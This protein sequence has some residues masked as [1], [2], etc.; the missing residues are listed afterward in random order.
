MTVRLLL[1]YYGQPANSLITLTSA[2]ETQLVNAKM[3]STNL[4][5]G[6][7]YTAPAPN[8]KNIAD[9]NLAID[10]NGNATLV[11]AALRFPLNPSLRTVGYENEQPAAI[12]GPVRNFGKVVTNFTNGKWLT[13]AGTPTLTQGYTGW[14]GSGAKSGITSRTGQPEMLKVVPAANTTE[15]ITLQVPATNL[16]N[17]ATAGKLGLWVYLEAQPGYQAGGTLTGGLGITTGTSTVNLANSLNFSWNTNQ[18]REGWNFLKFVQRDPQA[19]VAS[20]GVTEYHPF[21]VSATGY[22]TGADT[23][24]VSSDIQ[25]MT[26]AWSNLLGATLY[27]DSVWTGFESTAQVVLGNDGGPGLLEYALPIFN[28]YGWKGYFAFPYNTA[29]TGANTIT[30]QSNLSNYVS[31]TAAAVYAAGWDCINHTV[32]HPSMGGYTAE[33]NIAYQ[34][35]QARAMMSELGFQRGMEFY[36]S[37]QSSSSRL[38]EA[39]IKSTGIKLQRHVRKSNT[40]VTQFGIDNPQHI[41]GMDIGSASAAGVAQITGGVNGS[42]G[43]MQIASKIK[44]WVDVAVAYG[45]AIFPFWHGIT[46]TGDTGT[47]ENA[48]GDNLLM[49]K[50]AFEISMAYIREKELAG[51]LTVPR[52]ITGFWYGV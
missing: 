5:G 39:V 10:A 46:S 4:T 3:A 14:N 31:T 48:T 12:I 11:G 33:A 15:E 18:L 27:F 47:G 38:S 21:G 42:T 37:P 30:F 35:E 8:T 26:I 34:I 2:E 7:T 23:N 49:T 40:S 13:S 22:G 9:A 20:S 24:L 44:R 6:A 45:D 25:K 43:G 17:K 16:L 41:G 50:S 19:Y 28:S 32:T 1:D 52:G 36:A 29:D 51:S